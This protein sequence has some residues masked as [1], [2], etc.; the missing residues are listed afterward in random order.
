MTAII[1]LKFKKALI[2]KQPCF[3]RLADKEISVLASLLVEKEVV[4]G[5]I[6]VKQGDP[7]DS[8]YLIVSGE[9]DVRCMIDTDHPE[10][11]QS[12]ATLGPE[13]AIGLNER[14]FYS[15]SGFRTATVV[16]MTDMVLLQLSV[17]AFHGFALAYHH[18]NQIMRSYA[19]KLLGFKSSAF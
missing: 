19:E 13:Q 7:I 17:A 1:D 4:P 15:I 2:K 12:V 9:G 11:T 3:A 5:E 16:A 10:E 8:V 18:V 14:G 6:I